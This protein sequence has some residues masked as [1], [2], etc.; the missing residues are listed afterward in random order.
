MAKVQIWLRSDQADCVV[1]CLNLAIFNIAGKRLGDDPFM[2]AAR[3]LATERCDEV[4]VVV[5][6]AINAALAK[7]R[8]P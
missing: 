5:Q 1:A 7:A 6:D 2:T 8:T 4:R 3:A